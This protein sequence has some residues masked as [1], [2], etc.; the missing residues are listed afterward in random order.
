MALIS[1]FVSG[2]SLMIATGLAAGGADS[3]DAFRRGMGGQL[4][5]PDF[6]GKGLLAARC[7][8]SVHSSLGHYWTAGFF[9]L[10]GV[11]LF[12]YRAAGLSMCVLGALL[13]WVTLVRIGER[14]AAAI[15]PIFW[16]FSFLSS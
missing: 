3:R 8:E 14:K 9:H 1:D 15:L 4:R 6:D 11:N 13:A 2:F 16:R 5:L 12:V 10:F 7:D